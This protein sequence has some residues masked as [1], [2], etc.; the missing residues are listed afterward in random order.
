MWKT[1]DEKKRELAGAIASTKRTQAAGATIEDLVQHLHDL[2]CSKIESMIVL[3]E[4]LGLELNELKGIVH[5]SEAWRFTR[6]PDDALHDTLEQV[7]RQGSVE[8]DA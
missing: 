8:P 2:D 7:F 4:V 6:E 1:F 5:F 3:H